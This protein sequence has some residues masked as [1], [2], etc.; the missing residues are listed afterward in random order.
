[1]GVL[2]WAERRDDAKVT[3]PHTKGNKGVRKTVRWFL[4]FLSR[5]GGLSCAVWSGVGGCELQVPS[6]RAIPI[7]RRTDGPHGQQRLEEGRRSCLAPA[8]MHP[9]KARSPKSCPTPSHIPAMSRAQ[10]PVSRGGGGPG[11]GPSIPSPCPSSLT[12]Q[13]PLHPHPH[14]QGNHTTSARATTP[15]YMAVRPSA[16][17]HTHQHPPPPFARP[18]SPSCV[19]GFAPAAPT[20]SSSSA[21]APPTSSPASASK[22]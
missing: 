19:P 8:S 21:S 5:G 7:W 6:N 16:P 15:R 20:R 1:M 18:S 2:L 9:T 14:Q 11:L 10:S 12:E 17:T 22:R 13:T 4:S 3:R